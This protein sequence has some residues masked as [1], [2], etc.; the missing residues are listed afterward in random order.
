MNPDFNKKTVDTLA[1]R[2]AFRCSNPACR[3]ITVGPN[4]AENKSTVIG[5]A[6]HIYGARPNSKRYKEEMTD[7]E[8]ATITNAIWLCRNCH[9]FI[10]SDEGMYSSNTLSMWKKH[11]EQYI[12]SKLGVQ[13]NE[14]NKIDALESLSENE[15]LKLFQDK[16]NNGNIVPHPVFGFVSCPDC[17]NP[18]D[19][20]TE[21]LVGDFDHNILILSCPNCGWTDSAVV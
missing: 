15:L 3:V 4:S 16:I 21:D 19:D 14:I 17:N 2:S 1:K 13:S 10:D 5:E 8:R 11:H 20:L 12:L 9:K 18:I 7:S 6:A